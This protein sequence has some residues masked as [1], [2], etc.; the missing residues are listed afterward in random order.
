MF[1]WGGG[2][3]GALRDISKKA[4]R[5]LKSVNKDILFLESAVKEY[6]SSGLFGTLTTEKPTMLIINAT[7]VLE[8]LIEV[9]TKADNIWSATFNTLSKDYDFPLLL[10]FLGRAPTLKTIISFCL[11]IW[12]SIASF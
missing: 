9:F 7:D 8:T 12:L 1:V 4:L 10:R 5:R 2:R 3:R 11:F 6:S